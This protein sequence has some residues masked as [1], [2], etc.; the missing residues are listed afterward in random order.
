MKVTPIFLLALTFVILK[1]VGKI[2]WSWWWVLTPVWGTY[3]VVFAWVI[4]VAVVKQLSEG[5]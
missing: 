5:K 2:D 1:L 4:L 3:V